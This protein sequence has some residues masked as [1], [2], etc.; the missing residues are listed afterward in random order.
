[1]EDS[2]KS[3]SVMV[4]TVISQSLKPDYENCN[5]LFTRV[6]QKLPITI[7]FIKYLKKKLFPRTGEE[8]IILFYQNLY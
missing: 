1:M 2:A 4:I 3:K 7:I 8:V 6:P 5:T